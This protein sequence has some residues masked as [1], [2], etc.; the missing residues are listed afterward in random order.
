MPKRPACTLEMEV[1]TMWLD[2][3]VSDGQQSDNK[4]K[5]SNAA[6]FPWQKTLLVVLSV[7]VLLMCINL[8]G[9]LLD[10]GQV[11]VYKIFMLLTLNTA[12]SNL[13]YNFC[14]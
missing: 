11:H 13:T 7:A 5:C 2:L 4:R 6:R 12:P 14:W 8:H 1:L 3:Y 10:I 9:I